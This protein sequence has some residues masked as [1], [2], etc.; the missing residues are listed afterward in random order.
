MKIPTKETVSDTVKEEPTETPPVSEQNEII[1]EPVATEFIEVPET[2]APVIIE[3]EEIEKEKEFE[4]IGASF[5]PTP[6]P[7]EPRLSWLQK[8]KQNNPDVEKFIGE[9]LINKIGILILVLGISFFVKYAIDKDWINEPAR[10]G[11]G[12]LCGGILLGV[13]HRLRHQY[14]AFSSVFVAG[15]IAVFYLTIGI[16]FHDYHLFSQTTAFILMVLITV[17]SAFVAIV[18]DRQELIILSTLGGFAVPFMVSTGSGNF[19]VLFTYLSILNV[20]LLI[21]SYYKKWFWVIFIAF[22]LTMSIYS[23]WHFDTVFSTPANYPSALL[24]STVFYIIFSIAFLLHSIVRKAKLVPFDI[25]A[26]VLNTALYY[27]LALGVFKTYLPQYQGMF[28]LALAVYNLLYAVLLFKKYRFD[29]NVIYVLIGIALTFATITIPIQFRGNYITVFWACEAVML[30]W[31]AQKSNMKGF[32]FS[33][34]IVMA[35]ALLSLAMDWRMYNEVQMA[36]T[37]IFINKIF[38]TG[39]VVTASLFAGCMLFKKYDYNFSYRGITLIHNETFKQLLQW[40]CIILAYAVPM[41]DIN[42]FSTQYFSNPG[43]T[44]IFGYLYHILFTTAFVFFAFRQSNGI[45]Q[46]IGAGIVGLNIFIYLLFAHQ[47]PMAELLFSFNTGDKGTAYA[48]WLHFVTLAALIYQIVACLKYLQQDD[49]YEGFR[50]KIV[51]WILGF[52]IVFIAST[53][54]NILML[55]NTGNIE[56]FAAR[57]RISIKV[58]FPI[59]WGVLSFVFLITGIRKNIK[60]LRIVALSLLGIT[61]LKLFVYDIKNVSETGKIIAFILLGILILVISFVYQKIKR[62]VIDDKAEEE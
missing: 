59:L 24:Y 57:Q 18:Y 6:V 34:L 38:I 20:G 2:E 42:Y 30:L 28:T 5:N 14:K 60:M 23:F 3:E 15:A 35:L 25:S 13:A 22:V 37:H 39:L 50:D 11:I 32:A 53:E 17:F 54:V 55:F 27:A 49:V 46:K 62:L 1:P 51:P 26:F 58:I 16:A 12:I 45:V 19:H 8:F 61:I 44:R 56:E 33:G 9:N 31:L 41:I 4:D 40:L 7:E 52:V 47:Y 43:T 48:F 10:V 29:Y 21:I 36:N